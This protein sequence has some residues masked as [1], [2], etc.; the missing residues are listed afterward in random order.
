MQQ[1]LLQMVL[2]IH[3]KGTSSNTFELTLPRSAK[4]GELSPNP[5]DGQVSLQSRWPCETDPLGKAWLLIGG[6]YLEE[7]KQLKTDAL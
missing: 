4:R 5:E 1:P 2:S 3:S 6:L 7:R